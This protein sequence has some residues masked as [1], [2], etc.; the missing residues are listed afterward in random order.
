MYLESVSVKNFRCYK[1][2]IEVNFDDLTT[3]IG[4]NDIGKPTILE[5]LEIFFNSKTVQIEPEDATVGVEG[6][7]VSITCEFSNLP[8]RL[9][10]DAG[11][12]TTLSDEYL[13]TEKGTLKIKKVFDCSKKK[14]SVEIF[15]VALHP[16][17]GGVDNLLSLKE[18]DLKK[19]V[20]QQELY[21]PLKGNPG[22]RKALWGAADNL[23]IQEVELPISKA[24]EDS[25]KIWEQIDSHLPIFALF[26]SDRSNRDSDDEAK[27][28]MNATISAAIAEVQDKINEIQDVVRQKAQE[29]AENTHRALK[30][31]DSSLASELTPKFTPPTPAKWTGLFSI[32]LET[33]SPLI[34]EGASCVGWF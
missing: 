15:I 2:E 24:K 10:L 20:K 5:A 23:N 16:T 9:S 34:K 11:A 7:K 18:G 6:K 26:Q 12:E 27:N 22:M 1:E 4:K 17:S 30:S 8:E 19:L 29:I 13:L 33:E 3:F 32:N 14:P 28:P 31:F 21:V 25:K